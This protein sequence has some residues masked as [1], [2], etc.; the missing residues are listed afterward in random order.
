[1]RRVAQFTVVGHYAGH[2]IIEADCF[3]FNRNPENYFDDTE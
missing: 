3:V 1:M 2:P